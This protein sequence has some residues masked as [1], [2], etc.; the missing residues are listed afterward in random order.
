GDVVAS[1]ST[2]GGGS[3]PGE[4]LS[5]WVLALAVNRPDSFLKKLRMLRPPIIARTDNDCVLLDPR[6]VL[7]EQ[8]EVLIANLGSVLR[9][10]QLIENA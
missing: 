7:P 2:V 9:S 4:S 5:T 6:T 10:Y 1:E 3:L 8:D